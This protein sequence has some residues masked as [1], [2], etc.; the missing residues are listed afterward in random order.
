[1]RLSLA[2]REEISRGLAAGEPVREIARRL[3]RALSTVCREVAANGGGDRYRACAADRRAVRLMRRP[4][5]AKLARCPRLREAVESKL[6]AIAVLTSS[7]LP[8]LSIRD[9]RG[10]HQRTRG[11]ALAARSR[12][13]GWQA[14]YLKTACDED[15]Y[16]ILSG[17]QRSW[18]A[19]SNPE[20][21]HSQEQ[22]SGITPENAGRRGR[23]RRQDAPG[24][25]GE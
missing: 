9:V 13:P 24:E 7:L 16:R 3:R 23:R 18:G 14:P 25:L 19:E 20:N 22:A 12:A 6:D 5:P 21:G 17:D 4:K 2:E 10:D 15:R 8:A 1:L 11:R